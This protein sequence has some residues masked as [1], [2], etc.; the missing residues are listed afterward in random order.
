MNLREGRGVLVV[1]ILIQIL[2]LISLRTQWLNPFFV[3]AERA[4]GQAGD[5][6]G[7]YHAGDCLMQGHSVY[8]WDGYRDEADQRVPYLYFYRYLP[9]TAYVAGISTLVLSPWAGYVVWVVLTELLLIWIVL[10][11]LRMKEFPARSRRHHAAL[12]LAFSPFY[13]EQWM[14]QFSFLMAAFIWIVLR[15]ERS[16]RGFWAWTASVGLKSYTALFAAVY[17]RR[18]RWKPVA[19]CAAAVAVA[20]LPYFAAR[21][22][23]LKHFLLVN[24]SPLPPGVHGGTLG[25]SALVRT[26]S[27]LL[28][29]S[30][31]GRLLDFRVFD[32]FLGNTPVF[33]WQI[34]V[35]AAAA[36]ATL[37]RPGAPLNLQLALWVLAFFLIFKD[38]WEYHYVMLLPVVTL[39]G[40][41]SGSRFV[42]WMGVLL[43]LPTP[44]ILFA[45]PD[46]SLPELAAILHHASK[47]VPAAGLFV[48]ALTPSSLR[49]PFSASPEI[50]TGLSGR[51]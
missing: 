29:E 14:G 1:A 36:W 16:R 2:F 35:I 13:L 5:Y 48:W 40:L 46:E 44:Y 38:V 32:V 12:W 45:R 21:P 22:E 23:D 43:A 9:P 24:F 8:D 33:A 39:L 41:A 19:A 15:E 11:I 7:I 4:Y 17:L 20:S 30:I 31:A 27:W 3:E 28:P 6:F 10:A 50:A 47:A 42:F 34:G 26:V 37:R 51:S 49:R 18:G 25:A